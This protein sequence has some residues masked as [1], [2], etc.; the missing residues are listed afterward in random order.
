MKACKEKISGKE[1]A[2]RKSWKET[3]KETEKESN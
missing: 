2:E 1:E 3:E